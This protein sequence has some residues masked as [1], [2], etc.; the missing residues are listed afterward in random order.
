VVFHSDFTLLSGD[1]LT[2]ADEAVSVFSVASVFAGAGGAFAA[3][4]ASLRFL[5]FSLTTYITAKISPPNTRT[6]RLIPH[7]LVKKPE[8]KN[9]GGVLSDVLLAGVVLFAGAGVAT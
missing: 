4:A 2:S 3:S 8:S 1:V 9:C 7:G 6:Q 5:L